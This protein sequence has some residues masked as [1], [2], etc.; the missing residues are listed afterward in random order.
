MKKLLVA[1]TWL[2]PTL[3]FAQ[4]NTGPLEQAIKAFIRLVNLVIPLLLAV[5]VVVFIYAVIKYILL[6]GSEIDRKKAV[7]QLVW[8]VVAITVILAVW[9]IAR[10][11]IGLFGIDPR[12]IDPS[13][14]P[15]VDPRT[16]GLP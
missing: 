1:S 16:N 12:S 2:L 13:Y 6:A 5:A 9:G 14:Y 7:Q 3:A 10:L 11:L 8:S 15:I 4:V